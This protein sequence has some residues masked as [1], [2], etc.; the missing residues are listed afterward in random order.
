MLRC[1]KCGGEATQVFQEVYCK[2]DCERVQSSGGNP[3]SDTTWTYA[4][5]FI[6]SAM[7]T[8]QSPQGITRYTIL[9]NTLTHDPGTHFT[10]STL[11]GNIEI[12][13]VIDGTTS[14]IP[15]K[16]DGKLMAKPYEDAVTEIVRIVADAVANR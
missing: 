15:V 6:P 7:S 2:A 4:Y 1:P 11:N 9:V 8:S 14:I 10:N 13:D 3:P 12:L 5:N 16:F